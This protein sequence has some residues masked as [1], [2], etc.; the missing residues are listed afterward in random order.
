MGLDISLQDKNQ[1]I[2]SYIKDSAVFGVIVPVLDLFAML[3][4]DSYKSFTI[5]SNEPANYILTLIIDF[6]IIF[7]ITFLIEYIHGEGVMSR[8]TKKNK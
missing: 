6:I 4:I 8:L 7:V 5:T 2:I 1:R 3:F